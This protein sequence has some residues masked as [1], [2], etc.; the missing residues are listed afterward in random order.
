MSHKPNHH[1]RD[2]NGGPFLFIV[3]PNS[4]TGGYERF[5]KHIE[6][7]KVQQHF[8]VITSQSP[9]HSIELA[10]TASA[11]GY[12]AVIAVGGDG[13]VHEIGIELIDTDVALGII[14]TGSGNGISRHLGISNKIEDAIDEVFRGEIRRLDTFTVNGVPAIGF[15]GSGIDAHVAKAFDEATERGFSNY[16]KL[17]I[18]AF[19]HYQPQFYTLLLDGKDTIVQQAYTVVVAN[20]TQFGNNAYINPEGED[21]DGLLDVILVKDVP[22]TALMALASRLFLH[23]I[24]KSKWVKTAR[25]KRVELITNHPVAY[26]I[27]GE[28]MPPTTMLTFEIKPASLNVITP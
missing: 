19:S 16:V 7:I 18:D 21:D 17:S 2:L 27:D 3:N 22:P 10:K 14:P 23:S 20:I 24:H 15:C 13:S 12:K 28:P 9:E 26:Q 25:A 4:G 1:I 6:S 8:K 5:Q 11:E